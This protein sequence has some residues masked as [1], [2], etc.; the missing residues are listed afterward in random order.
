MSVVVKETKTLS[1]GVP[2]VTPTAARQNHGSS[3]STIRNL[4]HLWVASIDTKTELYSNH[5]AGVRPIFGICRHVKE[6]NVGR[7]H[8]DRK[9]ELPSHGHVLRDH[10]EHREELNPPRAYFQEEA[11]A[12]DPAESTCSVL[13]QFLH[14]AL[15]RMRI[16]QGLSD[17]SC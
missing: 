9:S 2:S 17:L 1:S 15:V 13:A 6:T 11:W 4:C 14:D 10:E 12:G 3:P 16:R 8:E 5:S 7:E